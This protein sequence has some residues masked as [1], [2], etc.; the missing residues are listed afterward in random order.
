MPLLYPIALV[1]L[2]V[3][4]YSNKYLIL[5]FYQKYQDFDEK[6]VLDSSQHFVLPIF[7]HLM[8]NAI[9]LHHSKILRPEM[10]FSD[11]SLENEISLEQLQ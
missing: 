4:Y 3:I 8:V 1:V 5:N 10:L 11:S 6:L 2:T 9:A 7:I